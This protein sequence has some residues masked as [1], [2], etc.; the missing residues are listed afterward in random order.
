MKLSTEKNSKR[1][2]TETE[3]FRFL[4]PS[5]L[6]IL[7]CAVCLISLTWAWFSEEVVSRGNVIST[8]SFAATVTLNDNVLAEAT[9]AE[10]AVTS[11]GTSHT[12]VITSTGSTSGYCIVEV[13]SGGTVTQYQ[14][15]VNGVSTV[16]ITVANAP[17]MITVFTH[18]GQATVSN[19][20]QI[21]DNTLNLT[22]VATATI[23]ET[24]AT[25]TT[26]PGSG[27]V[28]TDD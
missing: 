24:T 28:E 15:P 10:L 22:G 12:L 8:G 27:T 14:K 1:S 5:L 4:L 17:I 3:F 26:E 25:E 7:L 11:E 9:P 13:R 16:N 19:A 2:M 18:W 21:T 6:S 23:S 20:T